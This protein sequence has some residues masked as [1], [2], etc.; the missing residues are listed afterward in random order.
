MPFGRDQS[1]R[2]ELSVIGIISALFEFTGSTSTHPPARVPLC[3]GLPP[4]NQNS[5]ERGNPDEL[6]HEFLNRIGIYRFCLSFPVSIKR[7]FM[8]NFFSTETHPSQ[9]VF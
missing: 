9:E 3:F 6:K 7:V 2:K 5:F 8:F 4:A 1:V